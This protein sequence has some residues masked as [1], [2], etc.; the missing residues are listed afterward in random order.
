[1]IVIFQAIVIIIAIFITVVTL[2]RRGTH[3]SKAWKKIALVILAVAMIITVLFPETIDDIAHMVG[4]GRGADLL[5]YGTV[6]AFIL[7]ILN[8]YLHQQEQQDTIYRLAR[9]IALLDANERYA[10]RL[11]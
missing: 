6:A 11:K 5:L 4:V 1:M 10:K 9:K 3:S 2:G 8:N 7:Y